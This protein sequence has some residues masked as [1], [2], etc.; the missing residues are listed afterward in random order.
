EQVVEF[1]NRR[2]DPTWP[3]SGASSQEIRPLQWT[4]PLLLIL[5]NFEHL[6]ESG[7]SLVRSLLERVPALTC[8]VTSRQALRLEGE[9]EF[10]VLPL[11]TPDPRRPNPERLAEC[12]SVQ[13]FLDRAQ[14]VRADFQ[15]TRRNATAVA[16]L[17]DRLEGIPLAIELAAARIQVLTPAQMVAQLAQ[18]FDFLA[19]RRRD[20]PG[21]HR[22]LRAPMAWGSRCLRPGVSGFFPAP[23]SF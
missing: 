8:L 19:S 6:A 12:A 7:A 3:P 20:G 13:L 16:A 21:R 18:R 23:P 5:D 17:C 22:P 11:P 1:L 15:V 9:R 14:A 2:S 4:A 10:A